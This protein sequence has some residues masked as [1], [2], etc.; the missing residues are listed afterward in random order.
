MKTDKFSDKMDVTTTI[1][2]YEYGLIR[3]PVT[4]KVIYCINPS[5]DEHT[6]DN[7]PIIKTTF[8]TFDDVKETLEAMHES[9][10]F[11]NYVGICKDAYIEGLNPEHL[12]SDIM[13]INQYDGSFELY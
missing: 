6:K 9:Y 11:F 2:L 10:G 12:T 7:P 3:N 8:I 13:S 1:S 5:S 4:D